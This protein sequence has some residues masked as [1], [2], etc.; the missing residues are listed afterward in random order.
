MSATIIPNGKQYYT[1]NGGLPLVGGKVFTYDAGTS[2][3]RATYADAAATIPNTNP[4]ILD[5]RGEAL[6]YWSG[7]YKVTLQDSLGNVLWTVDNV[8]DVASA[9]SALLTAYE[10]LMASS[11]SAVGA[12]ALI[13]HNA[14]LIYPAG[15]LG[16]RANYQVFLDD[17]P[18]GVV[19]D[20]NGATGTDNTVTA[21]TANDAFEGRTTGGVLMLSKRYLVSAAVNILKTVGKKWFGLGGG[22]GTETEVHSTNTVG[23]PVLHVGDP[24]ATS[25][26][27]AHL[28]GVGMQGFAVTGTAGGGSGVKI[29]NAA[30][31][32]KD[33]YLANNGAYGME[34]V[35]GWG[36]SFDLVTFQANASG[37]LYSTTALNAVH[38]NQ[39]DF[40]SHNGHDGATIVAGTQGTNSLLFTVPDIEGNAV[41][42]R[43]TADVS[44]L[45][46]ITII[47]PNCEN[48]TVFGLQF[49]GGGN[50]TGANIIGGTYYG[51]GN[52]IS[53]AI[54]YAVN[55]FAPVLT[56]CNIT[57]SNNNGVV[58]YNPRFEGAAVATGVYVIGPLKYTLAQ[59]PELTLAHASD[60]RFPLQQVI[61]GA[62][63]PYDPIMLGN[64]NIATVG[65]G[66]ATVDLSKVN[67]SDMTF[68]A[69]LTS[70][71]ITIT[72]DT[73]PPGAEVEFK[74]N[75]TSTGAGNVTMPAGWLTNAAG[76]TIPFAAGKSNAARFRKDGN[77]IW[78]QVS[79]I[80]GVS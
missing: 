65:A 9:T 53:L 68:T 14:T 8:L 18:W 56:D 50:L 60:A 16:A 57:C 30:T 7:N 22:R 31:N 48:N 44:T 23:K 6:I 51:A 10:A 36:S 43:F 58:V 59:V 27:S 17:N 2:N 11:T 37:G 33:M 69:A 70:L 46:D 76:R 75:S 1:T 32:M 54:A 71:A 63:R 25:P 21:Q 77:N 28:N 49:D 24:T 66:V 74:F 5:A 47:S 61:G 52:G 12:G 78:W 80:T 72:N 79:Q 64:Q 4:V 55:I 62:Y 42:L 29:Y 67:Y 40:L 19:G 38:F 15:T 41:G 3:P 39:C 13:G 34:I 45:K 35:K 73:S 20:Y 26:D